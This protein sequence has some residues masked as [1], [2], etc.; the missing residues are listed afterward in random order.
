MTACVDSLDLD[1]YVYLQLELAYVNTCSNTLEFSSFEHAG[2][3]SV[4]LLRTQALKPDLPI[5]GRSVEPFFRELVAVLFQ[6]VVRCCFPLRR[7]RFMQ[8][9]E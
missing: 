4:T 9:N 5:G 6:S 7:R 1:N 8:H 3:F 2:L